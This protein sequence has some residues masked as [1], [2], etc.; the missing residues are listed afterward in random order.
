MYF[1]L[2]YYLYLHGIFPIRVSNLV[3]KDRIIILF[4]LDKYQY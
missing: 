4:Y 2:T 1:Y 3:N